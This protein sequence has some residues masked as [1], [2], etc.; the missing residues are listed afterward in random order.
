MSHLKLKFI[1][2][3]KIELKRCKIKTVKIGTDFVIRFILSNLIKLLKDRAFYTTKN[4]IRKE[5]ENSIFHLENQERTERKNLN[6]SVHL[7]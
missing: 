3:K 1:K 2:L 7:K 6:N 5:E 4:Y